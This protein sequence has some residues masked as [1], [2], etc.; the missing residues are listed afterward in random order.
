MLK[1]T[2]ANW[3]MRHARRGVYIGW[4]E[5]SVTYLLKF[6][7]QSEI[8]RILEIIRVTTSPLY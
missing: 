7:I 8:K 2:M 5:N 4:N 6:S 1:I 3:F